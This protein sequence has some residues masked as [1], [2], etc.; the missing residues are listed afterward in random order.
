[1]WWKNWKEKGRGRGR[2]DKGI[3]QRMYEFV[4]IFFIAA[5]TIVDH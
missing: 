2:K 5:H 3:G 4:Q 1:M